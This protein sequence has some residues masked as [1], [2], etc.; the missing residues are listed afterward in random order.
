MRNWLLGALALTSISSAVARDEFDGVMTISHGYFINAEGQYVSLVGQKVPFHG[1][2]IQLGFS[3]K[4]MP[5]YQGV[6]AIVYNNDHGETSYI[7]SGLPMPSALDDVK[8]VA[9]AGATW[10]SLTMGVNANITE[11]NDYFL[12]RWIAYK[13]FTSGLGAGVSAFS[14][15]VMDFGGAMNIFLADP[16]A[17]V[18]GTFKLTFDISGFGLSS[19]V[20][21]IYFAQQFR[22]WDFSGNPDTPFRMEFDSVFSRGFPSPGTSSENFWYDNEPDGIYDETEVDI[23]GKGNEANFLLT[24]TAQQNGTIETRPPSS[25]SYSPGNPVSGGLSDLWDSDNSYLVARPGVVFSS[26]QQ[27]LR[28]TLSSTATTSTP[29]RVAMVVEAKASAA[30]FQQTIEFWNFQTNQWVIADT[31]AIGTTENS[32]EVQAPGT[33]SNYVQSTTR[34]MR[35]RLGYKAT[36]AVFQYP[37]RINWDQTVWKVTRP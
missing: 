18:P 4:A 29:T 21:Q 24:I 6:D 8:M 10:Q 14:N 26:G 33:A 11:S 1:E 34:E 28:L 36:G 32:I 13:N 12:I 5:P 20:D 30:N 7:A 23:W 22:E 31:R 3:T 15:V 25:F 27:P 19:P 2:R 35:T 17:K 9:G 16:F 37:W